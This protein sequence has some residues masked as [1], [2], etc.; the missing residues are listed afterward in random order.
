[1]KLSDIQRKD[2]I[3]LK[4]GRNLGKIIDAEV[5]INTGKIT[6][7]LVEKRN[8]KYMFGSQADLNIKYIQIKKIGEDVIL[9][10]P[11]E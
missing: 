7:F 4:N 6:N 2:I 5:D 1:M 8:I 3:F 11:L 9:I 10:E